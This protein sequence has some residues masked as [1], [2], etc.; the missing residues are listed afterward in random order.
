MRAILP[1]LLAPCLFA[2][3][4]DVRTH[5]LQNGMKIIVQEDHSIPNVAMYF[6]Y[7]IGSRNERP[8]ATGISHFFEHMMF[9]GA[10][11]Y[12]P[13]QFD[14]Q[15]EKNGGNNNAY[16]SHDLTVYTD[17]FPSSALELMF[18]MEADRIRDLA[19]D[20]KIIESERGVVYSERRLSVDNSPFGA[21]NEQAMA[22][23]FMAHPYRWPVVG[24]ASDIESWTMDD[25]KSHFRMG[26][27]LDHMMEKFLND[28]GTTFVVDSG[29]STFLPLWHYLLENS[30]LEFLSSVGRRVFVHT[31]I[32]GGQALMD[33][34][35]GFREL[36]ESTQDQNLV[37]W[38]NE[39]FGRVEAEGKTFQEMAAYRDSADK[40]HGAVVIL[41]RNQDTFGRDMEEMISRKLTFEEAIA[42]P[43]FHI[44]AKQ[45][46][47]LVQRDLFDQL[48]RVFSS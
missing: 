23:A 11:K 17:W 46:L 2:G 45:R 31:V 26:Y 41:K 28:S 29:A 12:G 21:L 10:K 33:T 6:F 34:L 35:N 15:M 32:T 9:N 20:P 19:F 38:I 44:M 22:A 42:A 36:A 48:D 18:D 5:T 27:A 40:V 16:T 4:E 13:K 47:K 14:V 7:R 30:A 24:W 3:L 8:G 37:V 1:I 25:L 43:E 39:F